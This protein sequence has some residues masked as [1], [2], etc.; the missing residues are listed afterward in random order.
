MDL[1]VLGFTVEQLAR[2]AGSTMGDLTRTRS[3]EIRRLDVTIKWIRN[4]T[5][6]FIRE[7]TEETK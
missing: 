6:F 7:L 5:T 2:R 4:A 3:Y 1:N